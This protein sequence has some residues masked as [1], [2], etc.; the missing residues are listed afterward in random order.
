[1]SASTLTREGYLRYLALGLFCGERFQYASEQELREAMALIGP[2]WTYE[3]WVAGWNGA[4]CHFP[5]P[6]S[7]PN[8]PRYEVHDQQT[9]MAKGWCYVVDKHYPGWDGRHVAS[10]DLNVIEQGKQMAESIANTLNEKKE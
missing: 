1:M 9:S 4:K 7:E 8:K 6:K 10:F 5:D 3:T 2:E